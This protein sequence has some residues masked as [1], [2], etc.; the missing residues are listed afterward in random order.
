MGNCSRRSADPSSQ[1]HEMEI[2]PTNEPQKGAYEALNSVDSIKRLEATFWQM[3]IA[4]WVVMPIYA[5]MQLAIPFMRPTCEEGFRNFTLVFVLLYEVFHVYSES[6]CW[7]TAKQLLAPPEIT[8]LRGYGV[9]RKRRRY[10]LLGIAESLDL[11]TD[12]TFPFIAQSCTAHLTAAWNHSWRVVPLVG[13][14]V[15]KAVTVLRFWGCCL[16]FASLN[17]LLTGLLGLYQMY[18][19]QQQSKA[20]QEGAGDTRI[21]GEVYFQWAQSAETAMMPSVA[22]LQEEVGLQSKYQFNQ[23]ADTKK[24][25]EA[26]D[27]AAHGRM[28]KDTYMHHES[29]INEE[30]KRVEV[31]AR[32][33]FFL[34]ICIKVMIGN[35]FQMWMQSSFFSLT[36][37]VTGKEAKIK[38]IVS[39]VLSAVSGLVRVSIVAPKLGVPGLVLALAIM[40]MVSWSAAKVYFSYHCTHHVWN[41]T[42]GCVDMSKLVLS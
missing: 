8:I 41:L 25:M 3:A 36:F 42:T 30:T 2:R 24:M 5:V 7:T 18:R 9:L 4:T 10:V 13:K 16:L 37:D 27:K 38:I 21:G 23:N 15:T 31:A 39:M 35:I 29:V 28:A 17:V 32:R 19:A 11:Y 40:F 22:M 6:V 14:N 20:L 12:V 1:K 26:R 33:H 34:M